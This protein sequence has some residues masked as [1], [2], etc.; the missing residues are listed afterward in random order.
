MTF[1][2]NFLTEC[3]RFTVIIYTFAMRISYFKVK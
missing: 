3:V 1:F 2:P